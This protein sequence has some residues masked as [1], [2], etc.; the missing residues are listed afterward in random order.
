MK[1]LEHVLTITDVKHHID[2]FASAA[3]VMLVHAHVFGHICVCGPLKLIGIVVVLCTRIVQMGLHIHAPYT[4]TSAL[5]IPLLLV[6]MHVCA[7]NLGLAIVQIQ[8]KPLNSPGHR[9]IQDMLLLETR[10]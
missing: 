10:P 8:I 3:I 2:V 1:C 9:L 4:C 6:Y 7:H 5:G